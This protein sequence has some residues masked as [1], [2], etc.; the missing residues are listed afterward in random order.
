MIDFII[1]ITVTLCNLL[2]LKA[3]IM[4]VKDLFKQG[5]LILRKIFWYGC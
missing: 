3:Q 4:K 5:S 2:T 1:E